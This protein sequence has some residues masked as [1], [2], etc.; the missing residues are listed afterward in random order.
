M[1]SGV[2]QSS[3]LCPTLFLIYINDLP[4]SVDC[5]V[6]LYAD[7][8]LLYQ[9]VKTATDANFQLSIDALYNW[10]QRWKMPFNDNK[11][12]AIAFGNKTSLPD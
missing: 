1:T 9:H 4:S 3:V 12:Y 6:S 11:C 10:S 8:T 7:D 5:C 2:P